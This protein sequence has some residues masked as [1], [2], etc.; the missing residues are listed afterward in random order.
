MSALRILH[1]SD[2]RPGHYHL[3]EGVIA[4]IARN[5]QVQIT[6]QVIKRRRLALGRLLRLLLGAGG[7]SRGL[8]LKAGYGVDP[9]DL[10]EADLVISAG[11]ET[12]P[13]NIAAARALGAEN[14]FVGSLR[15]VEPETFSLVISSYARHAE[16]PRHLVTLKPSAVDPD[17]LGRPAEVPRYGP[18]NPP[19]HAGLLIGG[20]S[21][22]FKYTEGEWRQLLDFTRAVARE[23][24]T[25]W[26]ISTSRR[27]PQPVAEAA[28]V[29]AREKD[30]VADFVDYKL[31]GPGSLEKIFGKADAIL[32]TE[33]SSTMLSEAAWARLPV[34][35]V[36]P[37]NHA[38]KPEEREYRELL[39]RE[40]RCR[41]LPIAELSVARF[42]QA[43]GEIE[44]LAGNPL[45]TLAAELEARLP[46]L[47]K[48]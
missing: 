41:F 11:G 20:D 26:L 28:F 33:D 13:A 32:C 31:A 5:V 42:G 21:G 23:W 19:Q 40:N 2:D 16:K 34:V 12:L 24:G 39:A 18:D 48:R 27:T 45:D 37:E 25:R 7:A 46:E 3:A 8:I 17:T 47:F 35:G 29:L 43:L 38:F 10:G 30:V 15:G 36:A 44:P 4:A 22:L 6:K 14:I 1:L 9:A